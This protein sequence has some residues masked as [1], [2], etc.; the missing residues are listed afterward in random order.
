[1]K[2]GSDTEYCCQYCRKI[3]FAKMQLI[4][5]IANQ[6]KKC[7]ICNNTFPSEKVQKT[8]T[9]AVHKKVQFKHTLEREPSFKNNKN[10]KHK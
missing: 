4:E 6:H 7:G 9:K 8:H 10:K 3:L 2:K 1:M 5:H